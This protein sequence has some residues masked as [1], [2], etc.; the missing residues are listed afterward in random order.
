MI[1]ECSGEQLVLS[2]ERAVY[3]EREK[4]LIIS[5]LHIGKS[6]HFRRS[7]IQVPDTVGLTD[8]QRLT[9]LLKEYPA[10][11]LLVTGDMFHN[12]LN[13]D[14]NAFLE[15]RKAYLSL[16]VVLVKGN[17]DALRNEDYEALGIEVH[18]KELLCAPFRFIHDKPSEIDGY[19]NITGHIHP[20]VVIYGKAR[21][22]L[23]FPCFYFAE[24]CLVMPAFSVFTGLKIV[25]AEQGDRFYAITPGKVVKV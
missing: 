18:T 4:M 12:N 1:V 19:Y 17:H 24:H 9:A 14:A 3:W 10:E 22:Q 20:G 2:K 8:L 23:K 15:W 13:S 25:K 16:K 21:Q 11:I 5:D 7:G 6:A